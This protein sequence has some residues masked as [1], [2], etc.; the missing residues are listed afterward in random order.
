M[1]ES[2]INKETIEEF[3]GLTIEN[4]CEWCVSGYRTFNLA[5]HWKECQNNHSHQSQKYDMTV[6]VDTIFSFFRSSLIVSKCCQTLEDIFWYYVSFKTNGFECSLL[7]RT[8]PQQNLTQSK[9]R[10]ITYWLFLLDNKQCCDITLL[11]ALL[12][13]WHVIVPVTQAKFSWHSNSTNG[14]KVK[15]LWIRGHP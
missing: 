14:D 10:S 11:A 1:T 15:S 2:S 7:A 13:Q 12:S 9:N 6:A 3:E 5:E 8:L 4:T